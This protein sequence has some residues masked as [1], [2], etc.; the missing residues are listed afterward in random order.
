M[1]YLLIIFILLMFLIFYSYVLYPVLLNIFS[2]FCKKE[3]DSSIPNH[4]WPMVSIVMAAYNEEKV[5]QKKLESI[6]ELDYPKDKLEV[7]IGSDHST[8]KTDS[9]ISEYAQKYP[10]IKL[11]P[12]PGRSGKAPIINRLVE[13]TKGEFIIST[14][15]NVILSKKLCKELIKYFHDENNGMVAA[16]IIRSMDKLKGIQTVEKNYIRRENKIKKMQSCL[17]GILMGVEGGCYA[18]RKKLFV[19]VPKGFFMDDF[20]ITMHVIQNK[21]NVRFSEKALCYE[22]IPEDS[23]E[24]FKRKTRISIG[25]YQNMFFYKEMLFNPFHRIFFHFI[26][27]KFIRWMTPFLLI[28]CAILAWI[29]TFNYPYFVFVS[30]GLSL[31]LL[32]PFMGKWIYH[33]PPV[34]YFAH[35]MNMN[36]ALLKGFF[37]YLKNPENSIWQPTR[38]NV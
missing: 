30:S 34:R 23:S 13:L 31:L 18:I 11:I 38:R 7:L 8:D 35:F 25:N 12:F 26:S 20:F 1:S 33:V 36:Y 3:N 2:I 9:I 10:F 29:L 32:L 19:H 21:Y 27:H 16:N 6:L 17:S 22:D 37:L 4:E 15:A 28:I 24:E 5:I 14:D